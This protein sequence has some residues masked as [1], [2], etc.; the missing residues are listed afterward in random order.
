MN[1]IIKQYKKCYEEKTYE[2]EKQLAE[3]YAKINEMKCCGNCKH[4]WQSDPISMSECK[5][6]CLDPRFNV[7]VVRTYLCD[8]WEMK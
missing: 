6:Q 4:F 8:K 2:L 1:E 3:A 7:P 5:R